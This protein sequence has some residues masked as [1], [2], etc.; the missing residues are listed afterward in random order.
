MSTAATPPRAGHLDCGC[1]LGL[2]AD[3]RAADDGTVPLALGFAIS[4]LSQVLILSIL[5]LAGGSLAPGRLWATL[6]YAAFYAG[7][8]VASVPASLLVDAI[9]RRAAFSLG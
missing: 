6:P 9:G 5:P 8:A 7:A 3:H 2:A 1:R 4:V